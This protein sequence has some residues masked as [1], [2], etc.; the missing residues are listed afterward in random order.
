V[1]SI[2]IQLYL[3]EDVSVLI[4]ELLRIRGFDAVTARDAGQLEKSDEEQ[5]ATA[6]N[7]SRVLLTHNRGDFEA[8]ALQYYEREQ[9]HYGIIIAV[10]RPEHELVE[11]LLTL[12]NNV[13]SDEAHNQL[14]YI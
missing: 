3:D 12:L 7:Q 10:Q 8:L 6:I 5:L 14:I 13:A 1:D 4:A 11:R 9:H 2:F